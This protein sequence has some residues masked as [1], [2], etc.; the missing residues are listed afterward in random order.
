MIFD[1]DAGP[2]LAPAVSLGILLSGRATSREFNDY[3]HL[4][5]RVVSPGVPR[6]PLLTTSGC[7]RGCTHTLRL[8]KNEPVFLSFSASLAF[9]D[10][11]QARTPPKLSDWAASLTLL[12]TFSLFDASRRGLRRR[13]QIPMKRR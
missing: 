12:H 2:H 6:G 11:W 10:T 4:R 13:S 1:I 8:Q 7:T 3:G 9:T 5:D